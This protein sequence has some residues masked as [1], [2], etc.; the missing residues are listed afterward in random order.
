[1]TMAEIFLGKGDYY[2]GLLPLVNAY[3]DFVNCDPDTYHRVT[4]YLQ[5]IEK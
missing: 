3:L 4:Q 1:M 2:P 5:F